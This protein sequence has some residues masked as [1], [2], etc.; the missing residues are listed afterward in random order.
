[1]DDYTKNLLTWEPPAIGIKLLNGI[2]HTNGTWKGSCITSF[3]NPQSMAESIM[4]IMDGHPIRDPKGVSM[5]KAS[6]NEIDMEP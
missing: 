4:A 2:N 5:G 1:M 6:C 3:R